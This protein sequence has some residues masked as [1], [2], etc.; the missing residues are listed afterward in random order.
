MFI[1]RLDTIDVL[2]LIYSNS[3]QKFE[4]KVKKN[5]HMNSIKCMCYFTVLARYKA[6]EQSHSH[7]L[8]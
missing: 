7:T 4:Y 1:L 2:C 8:I 6:F 3:C 5:M